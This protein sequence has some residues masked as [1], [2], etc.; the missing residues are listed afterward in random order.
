M[1]AKASSFPMDA[2]Y[3]LAT[4]G[5]DEIAEFLHRRKAVQRGGFERFT[6]IKFEKFTELIDTLR[7]EF[8]FG[9][10]LRFAMMVAGAHYGFWQHVLKDW[11]VGV[12]L[13]LPQ[14]EPW[15]LYAPIYP[16]ICACVE[17]PCKCREREMK[18]VLE[19]TRGVVGASNRYSRMLQ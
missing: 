9:D 11:H 13:E 16:H 8:H 1:Q 14:Q 5:H 10:P 19:W 7:R 4:A 18:E 12:P 15:K 3:D 6:D 2:I 17:N